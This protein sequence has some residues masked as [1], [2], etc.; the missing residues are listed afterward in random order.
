MQ[1]VQKH[2]N[3]SLKL[4]R[5]SPL[6]GAQMIEEATFGRKKIVDGVVTGTATESNYADHVIC[7]DRNQEFNRVL[8][9]RQNQAELKL[10]EAR[11][12]HIAHQT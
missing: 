7:I 11:V 1:R 9:R 12:S 5:P 2:I 6:S 10:A 4:I 8:P 3:L